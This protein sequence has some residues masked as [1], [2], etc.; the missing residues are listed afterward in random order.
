MTQCGILPSMIIMSD[1]SPSIMSM[2][3]RM[4]LP[5]RCTGH[6]MTRRASTSSIATTHCTVWY[7]FF[8]YP[9]SSCH[10]EKMSLIL[11]FLYST[12]FVRPS[13][14]SATSARK[15]GLSGTS[16]TACT[17][18]ARTPSATPTTLLGIQATYTHKKMRP[19]SSPA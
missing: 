7:V 13:G 15:L 19:L 14:T 11:C 6:G 5:L 17:S 10:N 2:P 12:F 18:F 16:L 1:G 4:A 8:Y 3:R 9:S